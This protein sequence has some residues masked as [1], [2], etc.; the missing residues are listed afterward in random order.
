M[1]IKH[2]EVPEDS[3]TRTCDPDDLGFKT[4]DEVAPL[5]GT[6]GQERAVSALGLGLDIDAP[7]FNLFIAGLPGTGR[8]T[9]LRAHL[10]R[11]AGTKPVPPDLGV[12][13]QLPGPFAAGSRQLALRN[14]EGAGE[15]YERAGG[16]VPP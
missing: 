2:L 10:E 13:A 15:R 11:I 8:N 9:A 7:G 4:T 3:L 16:L 14:D 6:I 1:S 5:E 12:R